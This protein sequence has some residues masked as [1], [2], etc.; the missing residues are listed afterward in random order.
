MKTRH[1]TRL[2]MAL[3]SV[4]VAIVVS[5]PLV[6]WP[7]SAPL[8]PNSAGHALAAWDLLHGGGPFM[9]SSLGFP[10]GEPVRFLAW[11]VLLLTAPLTLLLG[12]TVALNLGATLW[13]ALQGFCV[14]ELGVT[15]GWSPT[16]RLLAVF[17]ACGSPTVVGAFGAGQY[18]NIAI[19]PIFLAVWGASRS[20]WKGLC[21]GALGV[22][23]A[24]LC[25]PYQGIVA[26]MFMLGV[27]VFARRWLAGL[28]GSLIGLG[29]GGLYF[30]ESL[31]PQM[32]AKH[33]VADG[34]QEGASLF[35]LLSPRFPYH[36]SDF[37][38]AGSVVDRLHL[39][40]S[41]PQD[42]DLAAGVPWDLPAVC[43]YVGWAFILFGLA[44]LWRAR[45]QAFVRGLFC[46]GLVCILMSF[47]DNIQ[48]VRGQPSGIPGPWALLSWLPAAAD[49]QAPHRFVSGAVVALIFGLTFLAQKWTLRWGWL[50]GL[51][52]M[53]ESLL[54]APALWPFPR[55][56]LAT[57]AVAEQLGDSTA[58]AVWPP[59][60]LIAGHEM[61]II[62]LQLGCPLATFDCAGGPMERGLPTAD[63]LTTKTCERNES[64]ETVDEWLAR[65]RG[66]GVQQML[67]FE[68]RTPHWEPPISAPS[69]QTG[70]LRIYDLDG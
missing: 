4:A 33:P 37:I 49:M 29:V 47:G 70:T 17:G 2:C 46:C 36:N 9:F 5:W 61:E 45:H 42:A 65:V 41:A 10:D 34:F 23:S 7:S 26:A 1:W 13:L 20:G 32:T 24:S 68:G 38:P 56:L 50:L 59:R 3:V 16:A 30:L 27:S 52:L 58:L 8:E 54:V 14:Q 69:T 18:E 25:S 64:G 57:D 43:T 40:F 6:V 44:G 55:M 22:A 53:L 60:N 62:T 35:G 21:V 67:W 11:P 12:G 66:A 28:V 51:F 48:V 15:W 39:A 31:A 63:R 19:L